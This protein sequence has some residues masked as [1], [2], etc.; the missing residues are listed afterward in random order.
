MTY[1]ELSDEQKKVFDHLVASVKHRL[2]AIESLGSSEAIR[3][4][5]AANGFKGFRWSQAA[6]PIANFLGH[7]LPVTLMV[8]DFKV[9]VR[10]TFRSTAS[11]SID[12]DSPVLS[13]II[14]FDGGEYPELVLPRFPK[15]EESE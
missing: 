8:D 13:F 4:H 10:N 15:E 11:L 6:C 2:D 5:L 12:P 9:A 7:G 14:A 1:N 3:Q